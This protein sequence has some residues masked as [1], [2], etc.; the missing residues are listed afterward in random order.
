MCVVQGYLEATC[1]DKSIFFSSYCLL[2]VDFALP[3]SCICCAGGGVIGNRGR[4]RASTEAFWPFS[5]Y[6]TG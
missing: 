4:S 2:S 3:N 5:I 1:I 6:C